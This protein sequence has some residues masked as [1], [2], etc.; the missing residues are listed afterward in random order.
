MGTWFAAHVIMYIKYKDTK[1][2]S[3]YPVYENVCLIE[4]ETVDIAYERA[5]KIGKQYE[6]DST[7]TFTWG[8]EPA[9][10][11]FGGI[12]KLIECQNSSEQLIADPNGDNKPLDGSE[13]TYS[14][15]IVDNKKMLEKLINGESVNLLYSE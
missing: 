10:W 8:N 6:G 14:Q 3:D 2:Q 1:K 7:G 11:V 12:R 4:A 15:F 13:I 9:E 5:H